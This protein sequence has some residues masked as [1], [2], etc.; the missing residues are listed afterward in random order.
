MIWNG[1]LWV[2]ATAG[3]EL[4]YDQITAT[5]NISGTASGSA[6]TIISAAAHTFDGA[7]VLAEFCGSQVG[8]CSVAAQ[9]L[10]IGL[11]E[12]ASLLAVLAAIINP[13]A[14]NMSVPVSGKSRFTPTA[15]SHTYIVKAWSTSLTGTPNV[16]ASATQ[17]A[18]LRFTKV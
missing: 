6:T 15:G 8:T 14:N 9:T 3:A 18:Y 11:W 1:T 4:G 13:T 7:P 17:P 5:V 12:G 16:G 2:P 10:A